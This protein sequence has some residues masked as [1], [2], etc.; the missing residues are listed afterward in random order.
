L[1]SQVT[2]DQTF[3]HEIQQYSPRFLYKFSEVAGATLA[4]D[5]TGVNPSVGLTTAKGGNGNTT[6]GNSQTSTTATGGYVGTDETVVSFRQAGSGINAS[7]PVATFNLNDAGVYGPV[8]AGSG[9]SR[10]LAFRY[11]GASLPADG[12]YLWSAYWSPIDNSGLGW[13][14]AGV[15][16]FIDSDG[17]LKL[18]CNE[19]LQSSATI[20]NSGVV[21][22]EG[23][24]HL[25][26]FTVNGTAVRIFLD[27]SVVATVTLPAGVGTGGMTDTL[28]C[29]FGPNTRTAKMTFYGDI[30]Y[31]TEFP[32][33]LG[34]TAI[35]ALYNAWK[36]AFSGESSDSRYARIL[37]YSGYKGASNIGAGM[38]TSMGAATGLVGTDA[39]S[40]LNDVASTE[41]GEHFVAADG[42]ITFRS[43][44]ARYNALTPVLVFGDGPGELP[45]EDLQ[46][47]FDSTHLSNVVTVTQTPTGQNFPAT[48]SASQA[49]YY[50]RT[51]TRSLNTT[52]AYEC[53]DAADYLISRYKA[54]VT[55]VQSIKLHPSAAPSL[56]P[57]LLALELG[58]RVRINR[59]PPGAPT[60]TVDCFVE[61]IT[62]DMDGGNEAWITLQCS[63]IDPN[64]YGQFSDTLPQFDQAL[65]AY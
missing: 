8:D 29:N 33:V 1:L 25:A 30:S 22:T 31:V 55:R 37:R 10:M 11:A 60:V 54:P 34:A 38:T 56:W 23:D 16:L 65:F 44:G 20:V 36:N 12:A 52:N 49:A 45:F 24:W 39:M 51:M 57:S 4:A 59:R 7:E 13:L 21:V 27:G 14:T 35:T 26:G 6:F 61:Q 48:D 64:P 19:F 9:Y 3:A 43:R 62:W 15:Q 32:S 2:L 50:T 18:K 47:D 63:P 28:G 53:Q 17:K 46:L 42:T 40:A 58:T 5:W 41:N